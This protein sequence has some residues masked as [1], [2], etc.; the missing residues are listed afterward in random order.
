MSRTKIFLEC[1][2]QVKHF[3]T[4]S[5]QSQ[6]YNKSIPP[7][8]SVITHRHCLTPCSLLMHRPPFVPSMPSHGVFSASAA[9]RQHA[10]HGQATPPHGVDHAPHGQAT[11]RRAGHAPHGAGHAPPRGR[12][13][14][15]GLV[16]P[17]EM[18]DWVGGGRTRRGWESKRR[19]C[20]TGHGDQ[21]EVPAGRVWGSGG[22]STERTKCPRMRVDTEVDK[23]NKGKFFVVKVHLIKVVRC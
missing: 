19:K 18:A 8:S 12:P 5:I 3:T 15:R 17:G 22:F 14:P 6:F 21:S 23:I 10:P 20:V 13:C 7:T 4:P 9:C 11:P 2:K 1:L 16:P